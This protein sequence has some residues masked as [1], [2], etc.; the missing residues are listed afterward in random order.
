MKRSR[1][2]RKRSVKR[3]RNTSKKK[4]R[5]WGSVVRYSVLLGLAVISIY[6]VYVFS[7]LPSLQQL[8]NPKPEYASRVLSSDNVLIGRFFI[9]NRSY[10]RFED[11]SQHFIHALIASEDRKFFEHYGIDPDRIAKALIKNI[12]SFRIRE[13]ASTITQQVARNLYLNRNQSIS[14]KLREAITAVQ[15]ERRF[16]K[17]KILELYC[18]LAYFGRGSYGITAAAEHYFGKHPSGLT[19]PEAALLVGI[20]PNPTVYDPVNFPDRADIRKNI[21]LAAMHEMKY[22]DDDEFQRNRSIAVKLSD[23]MNTR[24]ES[25]ATHFLEYVRQELV[26]L[27]TQ[28]GFDLYRDGLTIYTTLDSRMQT[29]ANKA[30]G[31]HIP[32]LQREFN[33]RW[34]WNTRENRELLKNMVEREILD[35]ERYRNASSEEARHEIMIMLRENENFLGSVKRKTTTVQTG[36]IALDPATGGIRAMVGGSDFQENRYGLN[37]A[38]QIL[39]QPGSAFKPFVYTVAVDKGYPP[40]YELINEPITVMTADGTGWS[41]SNID[42]SI[43]GRISLREGLARS[44]NIIAVRTVLELAPVGTVSQ[45]ARRMGINSQIPPYES[46]ALGTAEITPLEITSAYGVF[47]N[48]GVYVKPFSILRIEDSNGRIIAEFAPEPK[49]V[50]RPETA[51]IITD[52]LKDVIEYGTGSAVKNYFQHPAA[53]KTGT[54][55]DYADGWFI[56]YTPHIV[57]GVWVGFDD[58]RVTFSSAGSQA[59]VTALPV[60][61]RFMRDIYADKR[62]NIPGTDFVQPAGVIAALICRESGMLATKHCPDRVEDLFLRSHLPGSCTTHVGFFQNVRNFLSRIFN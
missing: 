19:L 14:R 53:G 61:A 30:V 50:V 11:I 47:A 45:Y 26:T 4:P 18:N 43:G 10:I 5:L 41:P 58:R 12:I 13:G 1:K 25:I 39:R 33:A 22:L 31:N 6:A 49:Q 8:E 29:H 54:T 7:G 16:S 38:T 48:M 35:S 28:Y 57:A 17:E 36:F 24:E 52:M 44:I 55:Q 51:Y 3:T 46:I 34:N 9:V 37:R 23:R 59:S 32:G 62:L 42:G 2:P 15:I 20:L 27:A 40:S 56:G 60:W 21:V